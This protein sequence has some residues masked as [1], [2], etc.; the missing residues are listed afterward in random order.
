MVNGGFVSEGLVLNVRFKLITQSK[1][2]RLAKPAMSPPCNQV[3]IPHTELDDKS[4]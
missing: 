1:L 3:P 2:A 4:T